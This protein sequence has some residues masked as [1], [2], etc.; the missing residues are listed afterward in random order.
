MIWWPFSV[1]IDVSSLHSSLLWCCHLMC[2]GF[3]LAWALLAMQQTFAIGVEID[4]EPLEI[5]CPSD[6][7]WGWLLSQAIQLL[8]DTETTWAGFHHHRCGRHAPVWARPLAQCQC[9]SA[10]W[11]WTRSATRPRPGTASSGCQASASAARSLTAHH[12]P[13]VC[14]L[15]LAMASSMSHQARH[16]RS[17]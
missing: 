8:G 14:T 3:A 5:L 13:H 2:V 12:H 10:P 9:P 7:T 15:P 11:V 16:S 4:G 6:R 1:N 17:R